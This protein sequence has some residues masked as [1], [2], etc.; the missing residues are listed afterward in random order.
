MKVEILTLFYGQRHMEMM[1]KTMVPSLWR[2]ENIPAMLK[3][4][5]DVVHRIYC[6]PS[7]RDTLD[8]YATCSE[9]PVEFNTAILR[10]DHHWSRHEGLYR[11]L[12]DQLHRGTLTV[13]ANCDHVFGAGLWKIVQR[14]NKGEYVVCGHPRITYERGFQVI[15]DFLKSDP[16]PD[17]RHLVSLCLDKLP[18]HV[19]LIGKRE[20]N[21]YWHLMRAGDHWQCFFGEPPP[22]CFWSTPDMLTVWHQKTIFGPWEAVDHDLPHFCRHRNRLKIV[23]DSRDFFW[24][25]FTSDATYIQGINTNMD[26]DTMHYLHTIP[27]RWYI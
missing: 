18:H 25:E 6:P 23:D 4:G 24:A 14:T 19:V 8:I 12:Q 15:Q 7:D 20:R 11:C 17:N 1:L 10:E 13:M 26:V 2:A 22:V 27:L 9:I 21:P 3:D 16:D 5:A